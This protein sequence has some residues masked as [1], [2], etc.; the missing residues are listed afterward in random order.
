MRIF[1]ILHSNLNKVSFYYGYKGV[2]TRF[3]VQYIFLGKSH[4]HR[5]GPK[6]EQP[7]SEYSE[8]EKTAFEFR[9]ESN[10]ICSNVAD[11]TVFR[12][13]QYVPMVNYL[14]ALEGNVQ[15]IS[16]WCHVGNSIPH[17]F[18]RSQ[19]SVKG[20]K[21]FFPSEGPKIGAAKTAFIGSIKKGAMLRPDCRLGVAKIIQVNVYS[22]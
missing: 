16:A 8:A 21:L 22:K 10:D 14:V 7:G 2:R 5:P 13:D 15:M 17:M 9:S 18:T 11:L 20:E 6:M 3:V 19:F 12:N 4:Y 1:S